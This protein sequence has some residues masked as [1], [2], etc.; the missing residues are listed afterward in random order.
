MFFPSSNTAEYRLGNADAHRVRP[1]NFRAPALI[2]HHAF[3]IYAARQQ[4]RPGERER[5]KKVIDRI[6]LHTAAQ[7][8]QSC[9]PDTYITPSIAGTDILFAN[10]VH[11]RRFDGIPAYQNEDGI[12]DLSQLNP[13]QRAVFESDHRVVS[14]QFKWMG[15]DVTI[16]FEFVT[17]YFSITTIAEV[18]A[19][20]VLA[21]PDL[22]TRLQRFDLSD[23]GGTIKSALFEIFWRWFGYKVCPEG[24]LTDSAFSRV[25]ADFRGVVL[26]SDRLLDRRD[27]GLPIEALLPLLGSARTPQ[28]YECSV[29]YMLDGRALYMTALGPQLTAYADETRVPV[30]YLLAVGTATNRWQRGRLIDLIHTAGTSRLAALRDLAALRGAGNKLAGMDHFTARARA[31]VS[32]HRKLTTGQA[33]TLD[34]AQCINDAHAHFNEITENFN[35]QAQTDYGLLYRVERSRYYVARFRENTVLLSIEHVEGYNKYDDFV[36]QRLGGTFD[37]VDRLGHRYE[38]AVSALSLLDGYH[39]TI[40][41]NEI[42]LSQKEIALSQADEEAE[43]AAVGK[44]TLGIQVVGEFVLFAVLLPYYTTALL[45]HFYEEGAGGH[46]LMEIFTSIIWSLAFAVAIYRSREEQPL[47]RLTR[48]GWLLIAMWISIVALAWGLDWIA[49]HWDAAAAKAW[50]VLHAWLV[51]LRLAF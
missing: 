18:A 27:N 23:A 49:A 2:S 11:T 10:V 38:R 1:A 12:L 3:W 6:I 19:C 51:K 9:D 22:I 28:G 37:F 43:E 31:A 36:Q 50:P 4:D 8:K 13:G 45:G 26:P 14:L 24:L 5:V 44:R 33:P 32:E 16:R 34:V 25:F 21:V 15:C 42:A 40:Q 7:A 20:T 47:R 17:E 48:A 46:R 39:L 30:T 29:S 41:S 35:R